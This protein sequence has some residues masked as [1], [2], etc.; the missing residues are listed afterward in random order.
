MGIFRASTALGLLMVATAQASAGALSVRE[1][2]SYGQGESFAGIAAGGSLSSL[3][4]NP[5]TMTQAPGKALEVTTAWLIPFASHDALLGST[6]LPFGFGGAPNA[7]E[8]SLV[9]SAYLS[10]QLNPNLWVGLSVNAPFGLS[11]SLP[12]VW[13]GRDYGA[14]DSHLRTYNLT[15]SFAYRFSDWLSIG[16]GVQI[17]YADAALG[18]GRTGFLQPPLG[19]PIPLPL[20]GSL[21]GYGW[22]FGFTAG[23]TLTPTP[24]TTIGVGYRSAINQDINGALGLGGLPPPAPLV[25]T[26]ASTTVNL[27]DMVSLGIRQRVDARWIVMGTVEWT[28]WSRIGNANVFTPSGALAETLPFQFKD[29]WFFSV[30]AEYQWSERLAVRAGVGYEISPVT[31]QVRIPVLPDNDRIWLSAGFSWALMKDLYVDVAYSHLFIRD[32]SIN[33]TAASG[34]PWFDG[35]SY[36][37][38]VNAHVD[39]LSLGLKYRWGGPEPVKLVTK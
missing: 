31:D 16:A 9:P 11:V 17:Q 22:G 35:I 21:S 26:S 10:S 34:N 23:L 7:G 37:G 13:A 18:T 6:L 4:W 15:P 5:A 39:I 20:N 1:Q 2:S 36:V 27:P 14:Q 25:S 19:G 12:R 29:G 28:N 8:Q 33:I 32:T 38:D 3:F 24:T 30:G